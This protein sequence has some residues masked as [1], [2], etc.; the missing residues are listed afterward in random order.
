MAADNKKPAD[1]AKNPSEIATPKD[2]DDVPAIRGY[3]AGRRAIY[4]AILADRAEHRP[5]ARFRRHVD[6]L[7]DDPSRP[8]PL[9]QGG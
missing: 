4:Y 5:T 8:V 6:R 3:H 2:Y 9:G 1:Q 7:V